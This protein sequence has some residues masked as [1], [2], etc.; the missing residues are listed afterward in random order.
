MQL[1][2]LSNQDSDKRQSFPPALQRIFELIYRQRSSLCE[3]RDFSMERHAK[4]E[5]F[6]IRFTISRPSKKRK[7]SP[8]RKQLPQLPAQSALLSAFMVKNTFKKTRI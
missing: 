7:H 2:V 1:G 3:Q 5:F 4:S 6:K 8:A